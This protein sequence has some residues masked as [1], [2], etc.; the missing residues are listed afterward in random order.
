VNAASDANRPEPTPAGDVFAAYEW[1]RKGPCYKCGRTDV[2]TAPVGCIN[3]EAG[4]VNILACPS[5]LL[6]LERQREAAAAR[7][8]WPYVPGTP[9][10][11]QGRY[12]Q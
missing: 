1:S 2:D 7:Y 11:C 3:P 4:P 10:D 6:L 5:C 12:R 9:A 8:G